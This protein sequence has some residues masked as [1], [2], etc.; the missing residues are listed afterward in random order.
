MSL[1]VAV[2]CIARLVCVEL[3]CEDDLIKL[4]VGSVRTSVVPKVRIVGR[5][6]MVADYFLSIGET[7]FQVLF[8]V[9]CVP[10][11]VA[12]ANS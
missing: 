6:G 2:A 1:V 5:K 3:G 9:T 10:V 12:L 4:L 7:V 8:L 11:V